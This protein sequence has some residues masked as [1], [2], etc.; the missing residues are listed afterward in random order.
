[1]ELVG[2]KREA[3]RRSTCLFVVLFGEVSSLTHT[4]L[5]SEVFVVPGVS[6]KV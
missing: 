2:G 1:M 3:K 5:K 4:R 6:E